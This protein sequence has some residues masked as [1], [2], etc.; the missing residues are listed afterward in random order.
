M[1]MSNA[2]HAEHAPSVPA[3][4]LTMTIAPASVEW[5]YPDIEAD[6]NARA[7]VWREVSESF[8]YQALE[9]L[10]P[11]AFDGRNFLVGEPWSH[12]TEGRALRASF[13][14]MAGRYFA[15]ISTAQGFRL[16]LDALRVALGGAR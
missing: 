12:T 11:V 8:Y 14:H 13:A 6:Y 7:L 15:T 10:P 16:K 5:A 4:A 1:T 9:V 2:E 3:A